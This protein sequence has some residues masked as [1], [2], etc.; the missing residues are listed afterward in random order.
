MN[1]VELTPKFERYV[2]SRVNSLYE[3]VMGTESYE[4]KRLLA[5]IDRLRLLVPAGADRGF[6]VCA[7]CDGEGADG[8][9]GDEPRTGYVWTCDV[10]DGKGIVPIVA[11]ALTQMLDD[12]PDFPDGHDG[13]GFP[14]GCERMGCPGGNNCT[15]K[16]AAANA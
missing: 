3:D 15:A 11:P 14:G 10:C 5:E 1:P 6:M 4:R 8:E 9:P 2:R 12:G 13:E 7:N 16:A